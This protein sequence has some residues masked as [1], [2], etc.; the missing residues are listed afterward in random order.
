MKPMGQR[1]RGSAPGAILVLLARRNRVRT[2]LNRDPLHFVQRD[3]IAGTVVELGCARGFVSGDGLGVLDGA[4]VFQVGGDAGGP[5]GVTARGRRPASS[6]RRL[7]MR[8]TSI[9]VMGLSVRRRCLSTLRNRG[10]FTFLRHVVYA[11]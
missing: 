9:L 11:L 1:G 4:A 3:V 10:L 2:V 6:E 7:I 8:N 5:E